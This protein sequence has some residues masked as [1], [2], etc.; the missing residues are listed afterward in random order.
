MSLR[1]GNHEGCKAVALATCFALCLAAPAAAATLYVPSQYATIQAAINATAD[2]DEIV[3][4]DGTYTGTGNVNLNMSK[5]V[6][7]RSASNDPAACIIDGGGSARGVGSWQT[8]STLATTIRGIKFYNCYNAAGGAGLWI[9]LT[10][11]VV[12]TIKVENC[13]FEACSAGNGP[14]IYVYNGSATTGNLNIAVDGCTFTNNQATGGS[15]GGLYFLNQYSKTIVK[16]C[17][18][19]GNTATIR[20]GA[21]FQQT[22][23]TAPDGLFIANSTFVGNYAASRGGAL[24]LYQAP[25]NVV[26]NCLFYENSAISRGT[27][28]YFNTGTG[29]SAV[30]CNNTLADNVYVGCSG[31]IYADTTLN[32]DNSIVYNNNPNSFGGSVSARNSVVGVDPLFVSPGSPDYNYRLQGTS[33]ARNG[34][35]NSYLPLDVADLDG[36]SDLT[37]AI[38]LDLDLL[39]RIVGNPSG[40]PDFCTTQ[41]VGKGAYEWQGADVGACCGVD[42]TCSV[43][44]EANC[45]D[46]WQ[47]AGTDCDP[48][49]CSAE[50]EG[51]C[52]ES[53]GGCAL[54][55]AADCTWPNVWHGEWTSCDPNPCPG[56]GDLNCDGSLNSLDIDPF[57][58]ALTDPV[59]YGTTYPDCEIML[60]D[61]NIDGSIDSLDI[62]PFVSLLTGG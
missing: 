4:A 17:L 41:C 21:I 38:P 54:T 39:E 37:E 20:G 62:D 36:D 51:A 7:L 33:T 56:P 61:T 42:D 27:A 19:Q 22:Y 14:S 44:T 23:P 46:M 48:N 12:I 40:P 58:L 32:L 50:P 16:N 60:A 18:F 9:Y 45:A 31:V 55:I 2:G 1:K 47:G 8:G 15:G 43:T 26:V 3:V 28:A 35:E 52:C 25:D 30:F 10:P 59:T 57:V 49:P 53:D 11:A 5:A 6:T 29:T 24:Y 13:V 34:G